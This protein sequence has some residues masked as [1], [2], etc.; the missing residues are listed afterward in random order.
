VKRR[1]RHEARQSTGPFAPISAIFAIKAESFGPLLLWYDLCK[2]WGT[3]A[4]KVAAR[5]C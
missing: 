5:H 1:D 4:N 2:K 3:R